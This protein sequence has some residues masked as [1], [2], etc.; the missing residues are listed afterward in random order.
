MKMRVNLGQE[1]V[2]GGYTP[3]ANGMDAIIVGYYRGDDLDLRRENKQR[4]RAGVPTKR[5]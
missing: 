2:I 1:F 5:L 3:G 4:L